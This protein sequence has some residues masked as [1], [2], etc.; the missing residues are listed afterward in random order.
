[1]WLAYGL[2][3]PCRQPSRHLGA[4]LSRVLAKRIGFAVLGG[5]AV[6]SV[7]I[8]VGTEAHDAGMTSLLSFGSLEWV[9]PFVVLA[10]VGLFAWLA[11]APRDSEEPPAHA[12]ATCP[13]C[14]RSMLDDWRLCPECGT[15]VDEHEAPAEQLSTRP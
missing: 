8:A 14:G 6:V 4:P 13:V 15:L 2:Q 3:N 1:V 10:S 5:L 7:L 11:L 12:E 9:V